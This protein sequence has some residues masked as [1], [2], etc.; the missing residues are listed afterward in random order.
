MEF[1]RRSGRSVWLGRGASFLLAGVFLWAGVAKAMRRDDFF[2]AIGHYHLLSAN[3]AYRLSF[4][5]PW[6][7]ISL[8]VALLLPMRLVRRTAAVLLALMLLFF[9]AGLISLWVR[10]EHVNC[11]CFGGM[12]KSHPVWSVLRNLVLL[13]LTWMAW[14]V[15]G[16]VRSV[17]TDDAAPLVSGVTER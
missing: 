14:R 3:A 15:D 4:W 1:L 10:G 11:G 13:A 7:E 2:N 5:I 12:G 8:A 6:I 9:T 16:K 17:N